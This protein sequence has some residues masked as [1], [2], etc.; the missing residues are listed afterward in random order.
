[1]LWLLPIPVLIFDLIYLNVPRADAQT[2]RAADHGPILSEAYKQP[3]DLALCPAL[4]W[5]C[6]YLAVNHRTLVGHVWNP[7][8]I[9]ELQ[10]KQQQ[11]D[12]LNSQAIAEGQPNS[13]KKMS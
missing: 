10:A 3:L 13:S 9:A 7:G 4:H 5:G 6:R 12:I 8:A 2:V 1:M 11:Q